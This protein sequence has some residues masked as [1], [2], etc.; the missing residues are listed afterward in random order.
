MQ[1]TAL[2]TGSEDRVSD[3]GGALEREGFLVTAVDQDEDLDA[4]CEKLGP[5]GVDCYVQLPV[6]LSPR[7]DTVIERVHDFL[8]AGLLTRFQ[9]AQKVLPTLAPGASVVLVSGNLLTGATSPSPDDQRARIAL[10]RVLAHC[11]L[12]DANDYQLRTTVVDHTRSAA[13][14]AAIANDKGQRPLRMI[15]EFVGQHPDM[16]Y[17]DWKLALLEIS[18]PES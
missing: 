8:S 6:N 7:G 3:V 10:L 9:M 4:A 11:L 18:E 5:G 14:I 1:R 12:A 16:S 17:D 13:D 15:A 2:V